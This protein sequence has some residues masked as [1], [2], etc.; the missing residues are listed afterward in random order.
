MKIKEL[1]NS[2]G[3]ERQA[4]HETARA[5][6]DQCF[7][8]T[9]F[10]R[11]VVEVSNYCRQNCHY[12]AMRRDN[13]VLER[14]R[15]NLDP[16]LELLLHHR[17]ASITDIDIQ[18]GEDPI[19]VR[20]VVI[21]LVR[22]LRRQTNL[23]ITLCLGLLPNE[24]YDALREA[25]ADYYVLKLETGDAIHYQTIAA[26]GTFAQRIAAIHYLASRGWKVSSGLIVGLPGQD[27]DMI[28][29][30]LRLLEE[31]PLAGCSVSP[32]VAGED[33]PYADHLNG[34]V[35]TALNCVALMRQSRPD[36]FIPAVSAMQL[37]APDGYVRAIQAGA[38]LTTI[39]LTPR[40]QREHYP[41]YKHQRLIMDEDRV[42]TAID[43][44][45][46]TPS[47]VGVS[48]FLRNRSVVA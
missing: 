48:E 46:C 40:W 4:L 8:R 37:L 26:P 25:G 5:L 34:N 35:E 18:A 10:V 23:G 13:H 29:T 16:L 38:N 42:L 27:A 22:E 39:N 32:F 24:M 21:P 15:L 41:I 36:W 33:T 43:R 1:L 14:Y 31:L 9:V 45:G 2:T 17:P 30:S 12:C 28:A 11:G 19:V 20:D 6:R 47:P 3:S 7:G 44:A